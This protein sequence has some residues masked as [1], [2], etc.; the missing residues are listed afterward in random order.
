MAMGDVAERQ[1]RRLA[2]SLL[3]RPGSPG[4][5]WDGWPRRLSPESLE[6]L[7][8]AT[9]FLAVDTREIRRRHAAFVQA[10]GGRVQVRYALKCNPLSG[11]LETVIAGGG[12]FE[13]ASAAELRLALAAGARAD[14][15][16][17]SNPVKPPGHIAAT[18]AAGVRSFVADAPGEVDKIA[19][20][21]PGA[22][23]I[24][25][26][27]V[28]DRSSSFPLSSKFGAE[29]DAAGELLERGASSGLIPFGV[30]FHVGSQCAD[31]RAWA[32]AVAQ[33]RPLMEQ[34]RRRGSP[35]QLLDLGGGF[36]AQYD[37][38]VPS[39]GAIAEATLQA[40]DDLPYR[41]EQILA[42]PGRSLVAEAGVMGAGVIGRELRNHRPWIYLD[43]GAYNGLMESAQTGGCW[44]YPVLAVSQRTGKRSTTAPTMSATITG[45]T[46][47]ATD[48]VLRNALLPAD[49]G[50]GD[51]LYLGATGAYT[52]CYASSFNGFEPPT[53][54]LFR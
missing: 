21:A 29:P 44:P 53:P 43:V 25:R 36:P 12:S 34:R 13:I 47:D 52:I 10:F 18:A 1:D 30:T 38:P 7:A 5:P 2:S 50:V 15:L 11:V 23:L 17:Y 27:R 35:L 39:M 8:L 51:R 32:R 42:E 28:D 37:V 16:V 41:P 6:P 20:F 3:A 33:L 46:C 22:R 48:T 54:I 31:V 49:I 45:P 19:A 24:V 40:I 9:P 26:Q 4:H 14:D